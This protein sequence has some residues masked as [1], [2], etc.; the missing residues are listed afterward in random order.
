MN[1]YRRSF[2]VTANLSLNVTVR[3]R[4]K[5]QAEAESTAK[6]R[7][8]K[9]AGTIEKRAKSSAIAYKG[10]VKVVRHGNEKRD[11]M[12]GA[13]LRAEERAMAREGAVW[14]TPTCSV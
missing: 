8:T 4:A 2:S 1:A 12:L 11:T 7:V 10:I 5:T 13:V 6:S 14:K 3:V 9:F